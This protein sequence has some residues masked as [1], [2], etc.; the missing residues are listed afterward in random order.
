[1]IEAGEVEGGLGEK[2][3]SGHKRKKQ[4]D[5]KGGAGRNVKEKTRGPQSY[6]TIEHVRQYKKFQIRTDV[7]FF[8]H[9]FFLFSF[10]EWKFFSLWVF[11]LFGSTAPT[12]P[13]FLF[14]AQIGE[15]ESPPPPPPVLEDMSSNPSKLEKTVWF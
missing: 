10:W 9:L 1:L 13:P 11:L 3:P 2:N 6:S 12:H 8:S 4:K 5:K 7:F 14:P 15:E